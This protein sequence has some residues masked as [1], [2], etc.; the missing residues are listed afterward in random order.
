M[1]QHRHRVHPERR[2]EG[3]QGRRQKAG[4]GQ[5]AIPGTAGV[6]AWSAT[7]A[8]ARTRVKYSSNGI[9]ALGV[10]S[11]DLLND[12]EAAGYHFEA[13]VVRDLQ[14]YAQALG[15]MPTPGVTRTATR[16]TPS[17]HSLADAG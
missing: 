16:S 5:K 15:A 4:S 10:S 8:T 14:I 2:R 6:N 11:E 7:P 9:A 1:D 12:L 13:L 3:T 17:S